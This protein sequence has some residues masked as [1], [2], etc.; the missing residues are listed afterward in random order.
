MAN[1]KRRAVD[2]N[3][4]PSSNP[5]KRRRIT[6]SSKTENDD[7][8]CDVVDREAEQEE[9]EKAVSD[10]EQ[11]ETAVSHRQ[12]QRMFRHVFANGLNNAF[13]VWCT[14][15]RVLVPFEVVVLNIVVINND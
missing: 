4:A 7:T 15:S 11:E 14:I 13:H 2:T 3:L 12:Q 5:N 9:E 10:P 6:R 1:K 8:D